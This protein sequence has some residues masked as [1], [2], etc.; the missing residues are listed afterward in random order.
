MMYNRRKNMIFAV[1]A[2]VAGLLYSVADYLL[3]YLPTASTVLN[4]YGIV[5]AAWA[6]MENWRFVASL[7]MSTVLTP[8]FVAGY[9]CI[10]RQL[11][12]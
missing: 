10:Y 4:R 8:F 11:Q 9:I 12:Y 7:A 6:D 2:A 5:E 1:I 3:E